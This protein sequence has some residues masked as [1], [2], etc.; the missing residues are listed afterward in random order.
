[1]PTPHINA[2]P[3]EFADVVLMTGDPLRAQL[4]AK[5]YLENARL[6]SSVRNM[7]GYTGSYK[8]RHLSVMAHGMGIPSASIYATELI[9]EYGVKTLIRVGTCGSLTNELVLRDI[10]LAMGA[11]TDSNVNRQRFMGYD[12]AAIADYELLRITVDTAREL[13]TR[14]TVGN[15]FTSDL[16][17]TVQPAILSSLARMRLLAVE[18]ELAGI[19]SVAA[20]YGARAMGI[21]TVSDQLLTGEASTVEERQSSFCTM[22][23]V[24]LETALRL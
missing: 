23:K 15:V 10:V 22:M 7:Y 11:S 13:G 5:S 12:F 20:E 4:I 2:Q 3:G 1:M 19:Y 8:G 21:L 18:M 14:V 17:Y 9:N 16:F 6:V 24:A